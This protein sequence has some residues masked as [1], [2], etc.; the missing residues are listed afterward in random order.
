MKN[1]LIIF[2][3][4][5][6][7]MYLSANCSAGFVN[8]ETAQKVALNKVEALGKGEKY[9]LKNIHIIEENGIVYFYL[10][11]LSPKGFVVVSGDDNLPP[12]IFYS[13]ENNADLQGEFT[14]FLKYD[15]KTRLLSVSNLP[16]EIIASRKQLWQELTSGNITRN[17]MLEQW[18]PEGTT[19]TGGWLNSTWNQGAPWNAMCPIDPVTSGRSYTGCPATAMAMILNFHGSTNNT[20][21]TDD[22]D[23]YH[24]YA[25]RTFHIDDDYAANGFPSFPELNKYLDTVNMHWQ[26]HEHLSNDDMAS[27]SFACGVAATQVFTSEGSGTFA[28]SQAYNAYLRFGCSSSILYYPAN[29][30]LFPT[31]IQNMKDTLPAHL[32]I[33]NEAAN[34]GHNVVVDGYNTDNYFHVNFGWGGTYN[35]WYLIP[36]EMPYSLTVIEGLIVD[37]MKNPDISATPSMKNYE[38]SIFPNPAKSEITVSFPNDFSGIDCNIEIF[39]IYGQ[40]VFISQTNSKENNI[41]TSEIGSAGTYF[42][43]VTSRDNSEPIS[44]KF[45]IE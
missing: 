21:F 13:F 14:N 35:G 26:I 28:V 20:Q 12:V 18:P 32:A 17:T 36:D 6:T 8:L 31:L 33:E 4:V 1:L 3:T 16:Q 43:K 29:A 22:D 23:Y 25:G 2:A 39:N 5:L 45:V 10:A 34:S 42:I 30:E 27:L 38:L 24:N 37:I 9:E 11:E 40:K 41:K 19:T 15:I 7:V 44:S